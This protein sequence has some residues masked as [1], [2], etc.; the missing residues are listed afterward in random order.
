MEQDVKRHA[1]VYMLTAEQADAA[2]D[3]VGDAFRHY[4]VPRYVLGEDSP[5]TDAQMARLIRFFVLARAL[6]REPIL[7]VD[8]D[9]RLGG[10]ALVSDP[11]GPPSPDELAVLREQTWSVLGAEP[12][13]RYE[14]FGNV[15][16]RFH[17]DEPHLHL[18]ILA[19]RRSLHGKGLGRRLL[20]AVHALADESPGVQGVTLT[21]ETPSNVELYRHFGYEVIG[22]Q[23]VG[24]GLE[25]WGLYRRKAA[26]P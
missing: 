5:D 10:V 21:T 15:C 9:G 22:H 18:N 17:V 11:A 24:D 23:P 7:A 13:R 20:D 14:H 4:P 12:R 3:V 6:R 25:T 1:Q 19:V 2:T 8:H 16:K 26:A